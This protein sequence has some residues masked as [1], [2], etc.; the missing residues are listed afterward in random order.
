MPDL[1]EIAQENGVGY[2]VYR[3]GVPQGLKYDAEKPRLDLLDREFIEGIGRVLTFGAKKYAAHNWRLGIEV[4]RLY[5]AALRHVFAS[6]SGE[7]CDPESGLDHLYHAGCCLMFAA[8]MKKHRPLMDD[9][10]QEKEPAAVP[11]LSFS[12]QVVASLLR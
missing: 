6:N 12:D 1:H 2:A 9:R 7:D 5:A 10:W 11:T 4:S 8:W 3:S